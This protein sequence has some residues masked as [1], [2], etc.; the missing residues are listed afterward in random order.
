MPVVILKTNAGMN[1]HTSKGV[2]AL[3]GFCTINSI[4]NEELSALRGVDSFNAMVRDGFAE[5]SSKASKE[6]SE[7][8]ASEV[9]ESQAKKQERKTRNIK[10]I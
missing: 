6:D 10:R 9:A 5:V 3:K 1:F 4:P 8:I 2:V 7:S